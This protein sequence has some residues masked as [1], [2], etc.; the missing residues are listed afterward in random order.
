[1]Q[2]L[3]SV[4]ATS[5]LASVTCVESGELNPTLEAPESNVQNVESGG[6]DEGRRPTGRS[7]QF[8]AVL[9][10]Q[11]KPLRRALEFRIQTLQKTLRRRSAK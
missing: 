10:I 6:E 1:M 11:R 8:L 3:S 9:N 2:I 7:E 5:V 4:A